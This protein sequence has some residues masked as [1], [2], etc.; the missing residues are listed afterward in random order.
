MCA[1]LPL[2]CDDRRLQ[3]VPYRAARELP[4]L[5]TIE[6]ANAAVAVVDE[7]GVVAPDPFDQLWLDPLA[8]DAGAMEALS[9]SQ[10]RFA[11]GLRPA[12]TV[13]DEP[14]DEF[15][16]RENH[17][18]AQ[19]RGVPRQELVLSEASHGRTPLRPEFPELGVLLLQLLHPLRLVE[20]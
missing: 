8:F 12:A 7:V 11:V 20:P 3:D 4:P 1:S 13:D 5:G 14:V 15:V 19:V 18:L 2:V 10:C 9:F 6:A 16:D 17:P